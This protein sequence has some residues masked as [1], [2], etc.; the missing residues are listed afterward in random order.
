MSDRPPSSSATEGLDVLASIIALRD[1]CWQKRM[2]LWNRAARRQQWQR[3]L[4][5][6]SGIITLV[7]GGSVAALL[8]TI[9]GAE[10]L[11]LIGAIVA[12]LAGVLSLIVTTYFDVKETQKMFEGA[13]NYGILRDRLVSLVDGVSELSRKTALE[14]L[15]KIREDAGKAMLQYDPLLPT[16][17]QFLR[18]LAVLNSLRK[19]DLDILAIPQ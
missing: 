11:K 7:S 6:A 9:S 1:T 2:M 18:S 12:F 13:S 19:G 15:G 10:N 5:L 16:G 3:A 4:H 17:N 8:A 14:R